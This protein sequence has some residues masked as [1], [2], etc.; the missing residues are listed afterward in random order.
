M[1]VFFTGYYGMGNF[2]D[3]L[4]GITALEHVHRWSGVTEARLIGPSLEGTRGRGTVPDRLGDAYARDDR[5]GQ[6]LRLGAQVDGR[7]RADLLVHAGGSLFKDYRGAR[8]VA[9]RLVGK[10]MK[11]AALGVSIGPFATVEAERRVREYL[12]RFDFISVRDDVSLDWLASSGLDV[13]HFIAGDLVGALSL[14]PARQTGPALGISL[15]NF[16]RFSPSDDDASSLYYRSL[17]DAA[18]EAAKARGLRLA[19]FDLHGGQV[20]GDWQ[21]ANFV[22]RQGENAGVKVDIYSRRD[23]NSLEIVQEIG[24]CDAM[25]SARLHGGIV[26]YLS[27]VPLVMVEYEPKCTG[28]LDDIG[29]P[30]RLRLGSMERDPQVSAAIAACL[31][32]KTAPLLSPAE[33]RQRAMRHFSDAPFAGK[34]R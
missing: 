33:Y 6:L 5:I 1:D 2:G 25:I 14:P 12:A 23:M 20:N 8:A 26:A 7:R 22:A 18:V 21:W 13:P 9:D 34:E 15:A 19:A 3:D 16:A 32:D 11:R 10:R 4:F 31:D 28:F 24:G 27:G 29:Q 17:V 30:D